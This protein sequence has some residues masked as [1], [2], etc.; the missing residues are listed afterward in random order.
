MKVFTTGIV[1]KLKAAS[2]VTSIT[3][4]YGGEEGIFSGTKVPPLA[5]MPYVL[6]KGP[7][8]NEPWEDKDS[9]QAF[10]A[11]YR[12]ACVASTK[13]VADNLALAVHTALHRQSLTVSG[14]TVKD[15]R[16]GGPTEGPGDEEY[17][18]TWVGVEIKANA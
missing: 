16:C 18:S 7:V 5:A 4:S 2:G 11:N 15:V 8:A 1:T 14:F 17:A 3:S 6:V 13:G 12:C 9:T 10:R